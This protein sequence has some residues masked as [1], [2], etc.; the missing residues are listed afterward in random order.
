ME[1]ILEVSG[2]I[3]EDRFEIKDPNEGE[4]QRN[5]L[6]PGSYVAMDQSGPRLLMMSVLKLF[7][8]LAQRK[9]QPA[10]PSALIPGKLIPG[11]HPEGMSIVS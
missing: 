4:V 3:N 7:S 10:Q 1:P 9:L 11:S 2:K 6:Y 5:N 8:H